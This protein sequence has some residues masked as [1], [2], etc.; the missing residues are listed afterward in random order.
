MDSINR[1]G[2]TLYNKLLPNYVSTKTNDMKHVFE[3]NMP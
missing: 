2:A 1:F 3:F